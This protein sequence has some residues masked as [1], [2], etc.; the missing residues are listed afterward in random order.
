MTEA[1]APRAIGD[2]TEV[3]CNGNGAVVVLGLGTG[4]VIVGAGV[5]VGFG[6]GTGVGVSAGVG[7]GTG[8]GDGVAVVDGT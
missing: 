2:V 8:A 1:T 4:G 7:G 5:V 6:I 3:I